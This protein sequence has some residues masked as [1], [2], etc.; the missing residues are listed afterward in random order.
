MTSNYATQAD[1]VGYLGSG[2][3]VPTVDP[4]NFRFASLLVRQATRRARYRA[5]PVTMAPLDAEVADA[6]ARATCAQVLAWA[7]LGIDPS[8]GSAGLRGNVASYSMGGVSKSFAVSSSVDDSRSSLA[9]GRTLSRLA[10]LELTD[11]GLINGSVQSGTPRR[12]VYHEPE[13]VL[14]GTGDDTWDPSLPDPS[15]AF[16]NG[17]Q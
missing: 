5:H 3:E 17:L 2:A 13:D 7:K 1:L 4:L 16:E 6:M 12:G 14:P 15:L 9:D 10:T 11:A 8:A